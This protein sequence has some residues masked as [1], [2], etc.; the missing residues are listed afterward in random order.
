MNERMKD[1]KFNRK[2]TNKR[3]RKANRAELGMTALR[4]VPSIANKVERF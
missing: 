2:T 3:R 4:E 1:E